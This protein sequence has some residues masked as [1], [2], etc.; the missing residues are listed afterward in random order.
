[1]RLSSVARSAESQGPSVRLADAAVIVRGSR[2]LDIGA[3]CPTNK[4]GCDCGPGLPWWLSTRR[5]RR[6]LT[7]EG[8]P[9]R[10]KRRLPQLAPIGHLD[11]NWHTQR[12]G[13]VSSS[14][15]RPIQATHHRDRYEPSVGPSPRS[16][17]CGSGSRTGGSVEEIMGL[18]LP[19][20][21]EQADKNG[22]RSKD[23]VFEPGQPGQRHAERVSSR[24]GASP[25]SAQR[26]PSENRPA[27]E[28]SRA[29]TVS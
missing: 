8:L 21:R 18:A 22:L 28:A 20:D 2:H 12:G 14:T 17:P 29:T 10:D 6:T 16:S 27:Y 7:P 25:G 4:R 23:P 1:M 11:T 26:R 9:A 3:H 24:I 5:Q 15:A 19:K 13:P